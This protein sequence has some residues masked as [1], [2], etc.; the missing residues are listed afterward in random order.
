MRRHNVENELAKREYLAWLRNAEGRSPATLDMVAAALHRF[1][2]FNR[3]KSFKTFRRE[4]AISFKVHLAAQSNGM[5]GKP[6]AKATL[7]STLK[8]LRSFF[9]WL[10]REPGYR[11]AIVFSDATYFNVTDNDARIATASRQ[12]AA[13][14]VDQVRRIV[15]A[16]PVGT[17]VERRDR[18]VVAL[19]ML[20]GGRDAAVASLRLKH[21]DVAART[22]FQDARDVKTKRAKTILTTYFPVGEPFET[23]VRQWAEEL[24]REHLFGPDDPLFPATR[25]GVGDTGL[26]SV[27]GLERRAWTTAG[28]IRE[29]F[30]GAC[31]LA[32]LPYYNPHSL[33]QT[34]M[35]LAYDLNLAPRELK[36]WSQNL[37]H[38]SVLTSLGSYGAL[39]AHEQADVMGKLSFDGGDDDDALTAI[40]SQ[41]DQIARRRRA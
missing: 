1:E 26:F 3:Y 12:R 11:R 6:L 32:G 19:I 10:S 7:Y 20:T 13:P 41:L 22:L 30:R 8:T 40:A 23:V 17:V 27:Q 31:A 21:L 36:A 15:E 35:R 28:P 14:S 18:A 9:E 39:S 24:A 33:R 29:T 16:M 25:I 37:G 4:Q 5:T 34:L 38:E 2:S